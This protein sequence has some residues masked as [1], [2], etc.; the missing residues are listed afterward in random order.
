[1][2]HRNK[3]KYHPK[4]SWHHHDYE[5][6][7]PYS[8]IP[9]YWE[10]YEVPNEESDDYYRLGAKPTPKPKPKLAKPTPPHVPTPNKLY[11]DE[12]DW[13]SL[14]AYQCGFKDGFD[15]VMMLVQNGTIVIPQP[16]PTPPPEP[17]PSSD[18]LNG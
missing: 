14:E 3:P 10:W 5:H 12:Y 1:M 6:E 18:V 11:Y 16:T 15:T 9:Y 17:I 8:P 7:Y 4:P 2:S 13:G